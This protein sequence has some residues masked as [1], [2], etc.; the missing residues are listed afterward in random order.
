MVRPRTGRGTRIGGGVITGATIATYPSGVTLDD[1]GIHYSSGSFISPTEVGYLDGA[2]GSVIGGTGTGSVITAGTTLSTTGGT[3]SIATGLTTISAFIPSG[4]TTRP[5]GTS[6]T[7]L[8][9][10]FDSTG[11]SSSAGSVSVFCFV[12][13]TTGGT[14]EFQAAPVTVSWMAFGA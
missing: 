9:H 3:I 11:T 10:R 8:M 2:G 6:P 13:N 4:G 5:T 1:Q 14:A 7:I 12:A